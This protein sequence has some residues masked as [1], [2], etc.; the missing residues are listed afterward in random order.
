MVSRNVLFIIVFVLLPIISRYIFTFIMENQ[1][2]TTFICKYNKIIN[3]I[4]VVNSMDVLPLLLRFP[5]SYI[6]AYIKG[7]LT[8]FN[9]TDG[10]CVD[11]C[12][13]KYGKNIKE[14]RE[15]E[16]CDVV[17]DTCHDKPDE[18]NCE[19][20][21]HKV[22]CNRTNNCIWEHGNALINSS[23]GCYNI[24]ESIEEKKY[25]R[26][27]RVGNLEE[28]CVKL[29]PICN[30][31]KKYP[32]DTDNEEYGCESLKV[33]DYH[34]AWG[35]DM[36]GE[37]SDLEKDYCMKYKNK[38]CAWFVDKCIDI[39]NTPP[40][41]NEIKLDAEKLENKETRPEEI[42]KCTKYRAIRSS[43]ETSSDNKGLCRPYR[44][45]KR[46][47]YNRFLGWEFP[48]FLGENFKIFDENNEWSD[49]KGPGESNYTCENND[50]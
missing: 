16:K 7:L 19:N 29:S 46:I 30:W 9:I 20:N 1:I 4:H 31:T 18:D 28:D 13:S 39:K 37:C 17:D 49:G 22:N 50:G 5:F 14:C 24:D 35:I 10:Y 47:E 15:N 2:F 40:T 45:N 23:E 43:F 32:D 25:D 48:G 27:G 26:C 6:E 11:A 3:E 34:A 42:L 38:E 44:E 36:K 33:D 21:Q 12:L 8:G 41:C